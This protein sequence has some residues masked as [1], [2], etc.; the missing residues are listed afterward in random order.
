MY[1]DQLILEHARTF[2]KTRIYFTHPDRKYTKSRKS[3]ATQKLVPKPALDNVTLLLG[4]NGSGKST[5]LRS[6]AQAAFGP[7][8]VTA[9]RDPGLIRRALTPQAGTR[10][11]LA[12]RFRLHEQDGVPTAGE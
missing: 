7:A 2:V 11:R 9:L 8:A 10:A 6:I 4:D 3:K 1:I 5:V 12:A